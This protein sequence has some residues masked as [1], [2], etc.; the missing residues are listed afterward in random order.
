MIY[1]NGR[2]SSRVGL[3]G[4]VRVC[5][6][7]RSPLSF[8]TNSYAPAHRVALITGRPAGGAPK[9]NFFQK[10]VNAFVS[11]MKAFIGSNSS[12]MKTFSL[13]DSLRE[14][15]DET[16]QLVAIFV[17]LIKTGRSS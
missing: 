17:P 2:F 9:R 5:P 4:S 1:E 11:L 10:Q 7:R 16:D 8:V 6:G 14:I 3:L 15:M 12:R 13:A